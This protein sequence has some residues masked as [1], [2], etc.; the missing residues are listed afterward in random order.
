VTIEDRGSRIEDRNEEVS[1]SNSSYQ[2]IERWQLAAPVDA[3][4]EHIADLRSY[5]RWWPEFLET[6]VL[7]ER[8]GVGD[9]VKA[10][11]SAHMRFELQTTRLDP[12]HTV[13]MRLHGDLNGYLHWMLE[14]VAGGTRLTFEGHLQLD[15]WLLH[16][17]APIV[18][19]V[20]SWNQTRMF[21]HGERGLRADLAAA[22]QLAP[23]PAAPR[24]LDLA[25]L[26]PNAVAYYETAGWRA[27]YDR[28]WP[29]AFGL[30]VRLIETQFRVPFPRAFLAA[31]QITRASVAFVPRDH[32][33]DAVLHHM[34]QFYRIVARTSGGAFDPRRVAELELRYWV[35]H[36]E[37]AEAPER[38]N[39]P[40]VESLAALHGA[41]FGRTPD[42]LWDSAESR[43]EAAATVDR[44]TGRRSTD[45]AADWRRVEESLRRAY[46]QIKDA[47]QPSRAPGAAAH[48]LDAGR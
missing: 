19:P 28:N 25:L 43:A 30:M 27:Y 40:L 11:L 3:V 7:E 20:V 22:G 23:E 8:G 44:I 5:P 31:L 4:W 41:L 15:K 48:D 38:D 34:E 42:E 6:T 18:R 21:R 47:G 39:R 14:P 29:L 36:R 12:P 16:A 35:I 45:V 10:A 9:R 17:L 37:L 24:G 2:V 26:D 32:K 1:L 33:L 46:G 13:E